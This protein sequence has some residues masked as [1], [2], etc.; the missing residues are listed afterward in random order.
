MDMQVLGLIPIRNFGVI[1]QE[2]QLYRSAQPLYAYEYRWLRDMLDIE[3]IIN[4]RSEKEIDVKF[5]K[6][7]R[8][9]TI[10]VPDHHAPTIDQA[11]GFMKLVRNMSTPT[12]IHC[13]HGHG[14]T[15]TFSVLAKVALGMSLE[16]ALEE[17]EKIFHYR[18]KHKHQK[19]FL[20]HHYSHDKENS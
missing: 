16:Q 18:F 17:E 9:T 3:H 4:L 10:S 14:R 20:L 12:L 1:D 19:D 2:K 15:S 7:M 6:G 5:A 8:I 11:E 13:A